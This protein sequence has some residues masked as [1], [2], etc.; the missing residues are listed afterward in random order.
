MKIKEI[1]SKEEIENNWKNQAIGIIVV[2]AIIVIIISVSLINKGTWHASVDEDRIIELSQQ[3]IEERFSS[4][5]SITYRW[6]E[7]E[8]KDADYNNTHYFMFY[9][10]NAYVKNVFGVETKYFCTVK[11]YFEKE[12]MKYTVCPASA[13]KILN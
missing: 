5:T 11:T 12:T 8:Y 1:P 9:T 3:K 4:A 6:G 10:V 13:Q 2:M 7:V